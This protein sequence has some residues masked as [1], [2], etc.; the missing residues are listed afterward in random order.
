MKEIAVTV[1]IKC[2]K[3]F[4]PRFKPKNAKMLVERDNH[5]A[6]RK[7]ADKLK[8]W[9]YE[10]HRNNLEIQIVNDQIYLIFVELT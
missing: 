10:N 9:E 2:G 6:N 5:Y 3:I 1:T 4:V 7:N 8:T